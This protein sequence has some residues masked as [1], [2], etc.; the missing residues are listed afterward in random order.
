MYGESKS[1]MQC[2][3]FDLLMTDAIDGLLTG[4]QLSRFEQHKTA[5]PTCS[6]MFADAEA[7]LRW[8][9]QLEEVD[10]PVNLARNIVLATSGLANEGARASLRSVVNTTPGRPLWDRMRDA[11][12]PR[13]IWD[14]VR[15]TAR[16]I[17]SPMATP[18]FAM[19]A[20][21]AFFSLSMVFTVSG[22]KIS[23]LRNLDLT[24]RNLTR[25]YYATE[26]RAVKYYEN[27]RLV[28][29]I[30]SRVRELRRAAGTSSV[31]P[32]QE[33]RQKNKQDQ[34]SPKENEQ[35]QYQNFSRQDSAS[36][37]IATFDPGES[38]IGESARQ[39]RKL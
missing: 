19:S 15:A 11:F 29:E 26:A 4:E 7:G 17:F 10:P 24:P 25:T 37:V 16:A 30:E 38:V 3:E 1:G 9:G 2:A 31:E 33:N 18:R 28:Y 39:R 34:K 32:E 21:M 6:A 35:R 20:G 8:L 27:I 23:D 36:V 14:Q 13:T 12:S 22:V 5:C